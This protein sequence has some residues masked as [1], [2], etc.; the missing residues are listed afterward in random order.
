MG[1]A[2]AGSLSGGGVMMVR[3]SVRGVG[4][5]VRYEGVIGVEGE[6]WGFRRG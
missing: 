5:E 6:E 3:E 2:V 4:G 1:G